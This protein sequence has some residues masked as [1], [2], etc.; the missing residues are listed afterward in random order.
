MM[1]DAQ[2]SARG[3]FDW[4]PGQPGTVCEHTL[5]PATRGA[6]PLS[7]GCH[8]IATALFG[9]PVAALRHTVTPFIVHDPEIRMAR[10]NKR[11]GPLSTTFVAS[12]MSMAALQCSI[13]AA[14]GMPV[15]AFDGLPEPTVMTAGLAHEQASK[16]LEQGKPVHALDIV[17]SMLLG[18]ASDELSPDQSDRLLSLATIAKEQIDQ[19][20]PVEV[21]LQRAELAMQ[22]GDLAVAEVHASRVLETSTALR[23]D[24]SRAEA[25][26][27]RVSEMRG[28]LEPMLTR[29]LSQAERDFH[30]GRYA[31]AKQGFSRIRRSGITLTSGQEHTLTSYLDRLIELERVN[32]GAFEPTRTLGLLTQPD[33]PQPGVVSPITPSNTTPNNNVEPPSRPATQPDPT[34]P[35]TY[36]PDNPATSP[37]QPST[38]QPVV[39][40]DP[41]ANNQP[42]ITQIEIQARRLQ[43]QELLA[44]AD[45]AYIAN[46]FARARDRYNTLLNN[47]S[48]VLD[49][50]QL[51]QARTRLQN[52]SIEMRGPDSVDPDAHG[53][54]I[55]LQR[56][57]IRAEFDNNI[58]TADRKLQEADLIAARAALDAA[59]LSIDRNQILPQSEYEDK[60]AIIRSVGNK[61]DMKQRQIDDKIRIDQESLEAENAKDAKEREARIR[62]QEIDELVKQAR[63]YQANGQYRE[64]LST[65]DKLLFKYPRDPS[66]LL[67]HAVYQDLVFFERVAEMRKLRAEAFAH[68]SVENQVAAVPPTSIVSY[69][70]EWR[71]F[72]ANRVGAQTYRDSPANE[73]VV[74]QL[75]QR[76]VPEVEFND[77]TLGDA[78]EFVRS[79]SDLNITP[80]W[81]RL[82]DVGISAETPI[83]MQLTNVPLET[84]LDRI[85]EEVSPDELSKAG[86]AVIDGVVSF[87]SD[88]DIRLRTRDARFVYDISDLLLE[89]PDFTQAPTLDLQQALQ[90][91]QGGGGQSP[92]QDRGNNQDRERRPLED[93]IQ[94][95]QDIIQEQVDFEG[96]VDNGGQTGTM[97][98]WGRNLIVTNTPRNH[99]QISDLL[100]QLRASRAVQLNVETRFLL[101]NQDFFEQ[102]GFDIDVYLNSNNNQFRA[103]RAQNP[104]IQPRDFFESGQPVRVATAPNPTFPATIGAT[105]GS[106]VVNPRPWSIIG[107]TGDS[108][109]LTSGLAPASDWAS[110]II[111]G[112]PAL[113]LAGSFIDDVSVDFL[114]K[115]TQ[116]DRRSTQ[117]TAPR[118]TFTNGQIA[119]VFVGTQVAY[120]SDLESVVGESAVGFDPTV[121]V[122]TEGVSLIA[123]GTVSADR[124]YVTMNVDTGV[125]RIEGF[126]QQPVVALAGGQLINSSAAQQFIQLPTVTVTRVQTTVNVPDQGTVLLG[127]QRLVTEF[128]VESGVP[129]LSKMPIINRFFTNRLQSKEEQTLLILIK[130]TVLIQAEQEAAHS[131]GTFGDAIGG[132]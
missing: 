16:L 122:T 3:A 117:L 38:N 56:Q 104:I 18:P 47:F 65:V 66:G 57:V 98:A 120:I 110:A 128:E 30:A 70:A 21:S 78:I 119:N 90:S 31:D 89:I 48:D 88:E 20:S 42:S 67:L 76:R 27:I 33:E 123:E 37:S 43:A 55:E 96:W 87:S 12:A 61:I 22:Q 46:N 53:Q 121:D 124:N 99:Q 24:R 105:Q 58:A 9:N 108:L 114:V 129:V 69:P 103:A 68:L 77:N 81:N 94:E 127:G 73:M 15:D 44:E 8:P 14:A 125:S 59:R 23:A 75:R 64:A 80:R 7:S 126:A 63:E 72:Q 45:Q 82:S 2:N 17:R 115:A 34:V 106:A 130:P 101:V 41:Q 85:A 74:T 97:R 40:I 95:I 52:S 26:M 1:C 13:V 25:V 28:D 32:G 4:V 86:W 132:F 113:G 50:T 54:G 118:L 62:A 107:I 100:S 91:S 11:S 102:I 109:G 51:E 131:P 6:S 112:A 111:G 35:A 19:L 116:A 5:V 92:F 10:T 93:M 49:A 39:T 60:Q 36:Q 29:V 83:S 79:T 84:L 71:S